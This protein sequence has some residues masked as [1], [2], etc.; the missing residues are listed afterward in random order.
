LGPSLI[1]NEG[2]GES[3]L[4]SASEPEAFGPPRAL[5]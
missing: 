1:I 5:M 4:K 2:H 3:V